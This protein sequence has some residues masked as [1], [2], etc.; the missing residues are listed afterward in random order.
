M[1]NVYIRE[2]IPLMLTTRRVIE[3]RKT[4]HVH[5]NKSIINPMTKEVKKDAE[6]QPKPSF[7]LKIVLNRR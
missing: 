5:R 6:G 4:T 7:Q 2:K 1:L 3:Q